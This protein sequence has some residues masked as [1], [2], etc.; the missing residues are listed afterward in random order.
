M[1]KPEN[2]KLTVTVDETGNAAF[3]ESDEER[4][5][6]LAR[7]LRTAAARLERGDECGRLLDHN[8]NSVGRFEVSTW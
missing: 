6:E 7:I 8:G 4:A 3:G 2:Y 5:A 1:G